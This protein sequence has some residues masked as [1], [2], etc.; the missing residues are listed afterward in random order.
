MHHV[1]MTSAC[2]S[3]GIGRVRI[4][5]GEARGRLVAGPEGLELRPTGSKVRQA[6]FNICANK[7]YEC[8]FLDLC[9]GTGLIGLEAL[10]RGASSLI[11][12][13]ENRKA[14]RAIEGN[15]K[16]LG[17]EAEVI[18]SDLRRVLPILNRKSFDIIFADPPYKSGLYESILSLVDKHELLADNGTL[19]LEHLKANPTP[20][21]SGA[22]LKQ[23]VRNYGQTALSFY[24]L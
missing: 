22:L 13:E 18:C 14:A 7:L 20:E 17:Y 1:T 3:E 24:A 19:V 10:S 21:K 9:A 2:V 8:S 16:Y 23:S 5:G 11:F 6:F 15:L 4:T 12:V